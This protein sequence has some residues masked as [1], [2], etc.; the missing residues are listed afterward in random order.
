MLTQHQN[1]LLTRTGPGTPAGACCGPIGSLSRLTAIFHP[2]GRRYMCAFSA[3][4]SFS[5]E[6]K[7]RPGLLGLALSARKADLS[8]GRIEG[9]GIRCVYHGWAFDI[10][11][12]CLEQPGEPRNSNYKYR[13]RHTAY[14]CIEVPAD[15]DVIWVRANTP[16][17][18]AISVFFKRRAHMSGRA[19]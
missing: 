17:I 8:Y 12:R 11:G 14:P 10:R 13:I 2:A 18:A 7:R 15:P 6:M 3:K 5:S 19:A 9:G 4:I 16:A 1:D